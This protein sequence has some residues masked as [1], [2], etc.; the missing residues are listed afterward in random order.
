MNCK[1]FGEC[2]SCSLYNLEYQEALK[3]K[4][5]IV[6][7]LLAPFFK[8]ELNIFNSPKSSHRARAEFKIW[9]IDS[10]AHYAMTNIE[11]NGIAILEECPKVI[12]A[13]QTIQYDLLEA[14]NSSGILREKLF[15]IEFLSGKSGE[16]LA[17]LIYHKKLDEAWQKEAKELEQ[18]FNIFVIGRA[19]KQ[20]IVLT[21]EYITESLKIEDKEYKYKYYEGGFTQPNPY[22]N[23]KMISWALGCIK[24]NGGDFLEAYC[25]LGNFT[26]PLSQYFNKVLATEISSNSIKAAKE[27]CILNNIEN[28]EFVRLNA[29]ETAQALKKVREFRRLRG[30]DLDSYNFT[31]ALVDPP[32]AGLDSNSLNL[33]KEFENI[34]YISCNPQTLARDLVELCK[35]HKVIKGAVFDQFPYTSHI[36]SGVYLQ[37]IAND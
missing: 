30:V 11:K 23:E 1:H 35:T 27:N 24:D 31:T 7:E 25:G 33:I 16:V 3:S 36:E 14:I 28:I 32:R 8:K 21:Q 18:K 22:V 20:K 19:R 29:S 37:R 10:K 5:E 13:I 15:S 2:G 9:H 4:K 6:Q 34:V 17:T 26:L 12:D